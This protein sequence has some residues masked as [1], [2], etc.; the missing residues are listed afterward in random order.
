MSYKARGEIMKTILLLGIAL[1]CTSVFASRKCEQ[2]AIK[3]I[4]AIS[5]IN[6]GVAPKLNPSNYEFQ[7]SRD[8][9]QASTLFKIE[10]GNKTVNI[11]VEL[12]SDNSECEVTKINAASRKN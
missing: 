1:S 3:A 5:E 4:K 6:Y 10:N 11:I 2:N 9:A 8:Y 12:Q 7:G